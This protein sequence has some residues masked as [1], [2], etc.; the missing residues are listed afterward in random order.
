MK[1]VLR[2]L[3]LA[4]LLGLMS[5]C[6]V[7][8]CVRKAGCDLHQSVTKSCCSRESDANSLRPAVVWEGE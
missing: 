4:L 6:C 2:T 5:G 7:V 3:T 1:A 8:D